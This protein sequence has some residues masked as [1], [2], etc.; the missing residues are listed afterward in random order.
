VRG[1]ALVLLA[2]F[3]G[4]GCVASGTLDPSARAVAEPEVAPPLDWRPATAQDLDGLYVSVEIRGAAAA[5]LRELRYWLDSGGEFSGAA[6]FVVPSPRFETLSGRWTLE[7]G[8]LTLGEG[9]A[10]A[11]AEVAGD[12]L[13][14][15]GEEG[16]VVL[17]R[18]AL[19]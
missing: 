16:T 6:L 8:R 15:T 4:A 2:A 10:P 9:A 13:R 14:I 12:L 7:G 17:E 3:A 18:R 1:L 11:T 5:V 19:P